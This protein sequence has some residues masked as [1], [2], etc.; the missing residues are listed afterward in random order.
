[1]CW[2]Y[3]K[4]GFFYCRFLTT[5]PELSV[6]CAVIF[7]AIKMFEIEDLP[8]LQSLSPVGDYDDTSNPIIT[9]NS[10]YMP[11]VS[12]Y[13]YL[14]FKFKYLNLIPNQ[15]YLQLKYVSANLLNHL[16]YDL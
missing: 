14:Q 5:L 11:H 12:D 15:F 13:I 7:D 1:M 8:K 3:F 4:G 6:S 10:R 2:I 9:H 16:L